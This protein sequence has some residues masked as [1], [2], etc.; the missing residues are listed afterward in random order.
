[1]EKKHVIVFDVWTRIDVGRKELALVNNELKRGRARRKRNENNEEGRWNRRKQE[2][3]R[4][5]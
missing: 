3:R 1:M 5:V 2:G 4:E